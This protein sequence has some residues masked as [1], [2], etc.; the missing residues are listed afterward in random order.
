MF[1]T[2]RQFLRR[3]TLLPMVVVAARSFG[4]RYTADAHDG[5]ILCAWYWHFLDVVWVLLYVSLLIG[6]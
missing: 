3:A 2:R 5:V 6:V 1:L 4:G